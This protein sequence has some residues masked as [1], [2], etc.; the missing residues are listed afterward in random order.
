MP[1]SFLLQPFIRNRWISLLLLPS[2]FISSCSVF[3]GAC[4]DVSPPSSSSTEL[5]QPYSSPNPSAHSAPPPRLSAA[6]LQFPD[7]FQEQ[8]PPRW[9]ASS[10]ASFKAVW[11][12]THSQPIPASVEL[13]SRA[14]GPTR[15]TH[16][17]SGLSIAFTLDGAADV[18]AQLHDGLAVFE[19]G[20]P[21]ENADILFRISEEGA[22][23]FVL[24]EHAPATPELRYLVDVSGVAGLRLVA[25][26]IEFLDTQGFP[27]LR[28][29][30]ARL[31]ESSGRSHD[32]KLAIAG[33]AVDIST[34]L[35][36]DRPVVPPGARTCS[37]VL[38]WPRDTIHYPAMLD[39]MWSATDSM[40]FARTHHSATA[41]RPTDPAS[42]VLIAG[43]LNDSSIPVAPA[44]VYDP[45]ARTFAVTGSLNEARL[46]H[47]ATAIEFKD[48]NNNIRWR[49]L[50]TGGRKVADDPP[51][52][53]ALPSKIELFQRSAGKFYSQ[54]VPA[55][56]NEPPLNTRYIHTSTR[57][58]PSKVLIAGGADGTG[59]PLPSAYILTLDPS[60]DADGSI[61]VPLGSS[62]LMNS[63]RAGHIAVALSP[64]PAPANASVLLAGGLVNINTAQASAE[65]FNDNA[66]PKFQDTPTNMK[67]AR[68]FHT[69]TLMD[70][71]RVLIAGG[72]SGS[73]PNTS[74]LW[75]NAEIY[76]I[77]SG[78]TPDL[79]SGEFLRTRHSSTLL[80]NGDVLLAGGYGR[81]P[82]T[83]PAS[84]AVLQKT[85]VFCPDQ[86]KLL[87][88][89]DLPAPRMGHA[90]VATNTG[91]G[92]GA[93]RTVLISGGASTKPAMSVNT[94]GTDTAYLL[95]RGLGEP[96]AVDKQCESGQC[97]DGVCCD[98]PCDAP[99]MACRADLKEI[100][101]AQNNGKCGPEKQGT[102]TSITCVEGIKTFNGC[103]GKGNSVPQST[104]NCAPYI[105]NSARNDCTAGCADS[106]QCSSEGW[107]NFEQGFT[108]L[109][110]GCPL[111]PQP[112]SG[113]AGGMGGA[114]GIGGMGGSGGVIDSGIFIDPCLEGD[115]GSAGGAGGT[116]GAGGAAAGSGGAGGGGGGVLIIGACAC[117]KPIGQGCAKAE[118]CI[119]NF[120][121]DGFCC[122]SKCDVSCRSCAESGF[123]GL[124]TRW[125]SIDKHEPPRN[126]W[127]VTGD[128]MD[129]GL[130]DGGG[131]GGGGGGG[132]APGFRPDCVGEGQCKG[133]CDG[134]SDDCQYPPEGSACGLASCINGVAESQSCQ[135]HLCKSDPSDPCFPYIC[136]NG[137]GMDGGVPRPACKENC[138]SDIDCDEDGF[139][140]LGKCQPLI[141]PRCDGDH[142]LRIPDADDIDCEPLRCKGSACL[143]G[144]KSHLDCIEGKVCKL[145]GLELGECIDLPPPPGLPV[146]DPSCGCIAVGASPDKGVGIV[147]ITGFVVAGIVG[148]GGL[149]SRRRQSAGKNSKKMP[150]RKK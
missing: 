66:A 20:W 83:A 111:N 107:C 65:I 106:S 89:G 130:D 126:P 124:C 105:C 38:T 13:P 129:G 17:R 7:L 122:E 101:L 35:P 61:I 87:E 127:P 139:C 57:I 51:G 49:V 104:V 1:K 91:S 142:T 98:S 144:C 27:R 140:E 47:S 16:R 37:V 147:W 41:I 11:D 145:S 95:I 143:P 113:G 15:L 103:D 137:E 63:Q 134:Q 114:G 59:Q 26:T 54:D 97:V 85:E 8:N 80:P 9:I 76:D 78:F 109:P 94:K 96:C 73:D 116:G 31:I 58:A 133:F 70:D 56:P 125:G 53:N 5:P 148:R 138:S 69:A 40:T 68:V 39:P 67:V 77:T 150:R 108:S 117:K 81:L 34:A 99:C 55:A 3:P 74:A 6:Q 44:E 72:Q 92:E 136:D 10:P 123:E 22:E 90:A 12:S 36:W 33:C 112:G 52:V 30:R 118:E 28:T 4:S 132:P 24:F 42:P 60:P 121:I 50:I 128:K 23:D 75:G 88:Y 29:H 141:E 18:P 45:V 100:S 146:W 62:V 64:E 21:S 135:M 19:R 120:C 84:N 43:G 102:P 82:N 48:G 79:F 86:Q 119:S 149:V 110:N 2:A 32:V 131:G 25:N 14:S 71:T 93:G 115:G 46:D